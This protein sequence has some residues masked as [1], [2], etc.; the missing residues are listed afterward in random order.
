L[1]RE[2]VVLL[3]DV[4]RARRLKDTMTIRNAAFVFSKNRACPHLQFTPHL[5]HLHIYTFT[6]LHIY[7]FTP[8]TD[9]VCDVNEQGG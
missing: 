4:K 1:R 7:T 2:L 6:H 9:D 8:F 5:H 3:N